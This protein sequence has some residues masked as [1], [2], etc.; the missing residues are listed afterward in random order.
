MQP[1]GSPICNIHFRTVLLEVWLTD[2]HLSTNYL[3]QSPAR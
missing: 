3:F 1:L 2:W